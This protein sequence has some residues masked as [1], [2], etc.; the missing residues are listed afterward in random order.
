MVLE[1]AQRRLV[2]LGVADDASVGLDERDAVRERGAG[3]VGERVERRVRHATVRRP[4][5]LRAAARRTLFAEAV[6][7]PPV[8]ACYSQDDED[9]RNQQRADEQAL[10]E[11][12]ALR[13]WAARRR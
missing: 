2:E 10:G 11:G 7:E 1:A 12:Q 9:T 6:A 4:V 5:A 13:V 8:Q 3:S